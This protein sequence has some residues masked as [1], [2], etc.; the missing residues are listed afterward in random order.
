[1]AGLTRAAAME[2]LRLRRGVMA[3]DGGD[4]EEDARTHLRRRQRGVPAPLT[5]S[6]LRRRL[7][8]S[9]HGPWFL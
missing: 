8:W 4:R 3:R 6:N 5:W 2:F 1:M 9:S 7:L